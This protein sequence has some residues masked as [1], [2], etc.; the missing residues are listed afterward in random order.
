ML[1]LSVTSLIRAIVILIFSHIF[2]DSLLISQFD[3]DMILAYTE[4]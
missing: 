3:V 1:L 2:Y 4:F